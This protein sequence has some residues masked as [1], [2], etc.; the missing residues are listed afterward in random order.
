MAATRING[1]GIKLIGNYL[2]LPLEVDRAYSKKKTLRKNGVTT[3]SALMV[4]VL[5]ENKP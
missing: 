3:K 1:A 4:K 2:Y 5:V